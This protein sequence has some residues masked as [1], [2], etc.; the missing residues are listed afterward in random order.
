MNVIT[1]LEHIGKPAASALPRL[2]TLLQRAKVDDQRIAIATAVWKIDDDPSLALAV[3]PE[4]PVTT[5]PPA[6]ALG[7]KTAVEIDRPE[8]VPFVLR[9]LE[10]ASGEV[11]CAA[12]DALGTLGQHARIAA[13]RGLEAALADRDDDRVRC[14]AGVNWLKL[15]GRAEIVV[16]V[17]DDILVSPSFKTAYQDEAFIRQSKTPI[18]P[19]SRS[20]SSPSSEPS[21]LSP[22][23]R[24]GLSSFSTPTPRCT[25]PSR[26]P[27]SASGPGSHGAA[28]RA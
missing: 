5:Y 28:T 4:V 16:A 25:A 7:V 26:K 14:R 6:L 23:R 18:P 15:D 2:K 11:R 1:T 24:F 20:T 9:A 13:L 19:R 10:S 21:A 12:A 27:S 8:L 3:L 22:L 17:F